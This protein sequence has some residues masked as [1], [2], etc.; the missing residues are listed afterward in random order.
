MAVAAVRQEAQREVARV[1]AKAKAM[2]RA[3]GVQRR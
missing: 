3:N 1:K 2:I